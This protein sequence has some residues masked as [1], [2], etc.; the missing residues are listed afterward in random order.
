MAKRKREQNKKDGEPRWRAIAGLASIILPPEHRHVVAEVDRLRACYMSH[1]PNQ[2]ITEIESLGISGCRKGVT[3]NTLKL[4]LDVVEVCDPE[5]GAAKD[6]ADILAIYQIVLEREDLVD[7]VVKAAS[8]CSEEQSKGSEV[9]TD[10]VEK[11]IAALRA[12]QGDE[13]ELRVVI[14]AMFDD[15]DLGASGRKKV[16]AEVTGAPARRLGSDS[17]RR[18]EIERWAAAKVRSANRSNDRM[19]ETTRF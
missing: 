8:V 2:I 1:S 17:A 11:H 15:E 7:R 9:M 10:P 3:H 5:R 13:A 14:A 12:A 6:V 18:D 19:M 16:A 4:V